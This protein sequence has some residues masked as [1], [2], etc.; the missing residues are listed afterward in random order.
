MFYLIFK[1]FIPVIIRLF[2]EGHVPGHHGQRLSGGIPT[3]FEEPCSRWIVKQTLPLLAG[4]MFCMS[5]M[6]KLV[7]KQWKEIYQM[8]ALSVLLGYFLLFL[9]LITVKNTLNL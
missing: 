9:H 4:I 6:K 5:V 7:L 3:T 1:M 2:Y 8:W